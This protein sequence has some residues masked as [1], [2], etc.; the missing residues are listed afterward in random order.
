MARMSVASG[1]SSSPAWDHRQPIQVQ[2]AHR[3]L[4]GGSHFRSCREFEFK[5]AALLAPYYEQIQFGTIVRSP[6]ITFSRVG[7]QMSN[8]V[9]QTESLPRRFDLGMTQQVVAGLQIE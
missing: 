4:H 6:E 2:V 7:S 1:N 3:N 9:L 8:E 5:T